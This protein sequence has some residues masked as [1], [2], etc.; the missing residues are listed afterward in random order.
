VRALRHVSDTLDQSGWL[1]GL[2]DP[3][4]AAALEAMHTARPTLDR[5]RPRTLGGAVP[6]RLRGRYLLALRM[7][8]ARTLLRD[9]RATVASVAA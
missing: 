5:G 8:R 1:L 4:V 3:Y 6:G 7:Q 9:Q 2:R